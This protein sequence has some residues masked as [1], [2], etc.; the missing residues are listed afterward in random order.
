MLLGLQLFID[1]ADDVLSPDELVSLAE[2]HHQRASFLCL[3]LLL[4]SISLIHHFLT[5]LFI[6]HS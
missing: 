2:W 4:E 3:S 5:P 1:V 6:I